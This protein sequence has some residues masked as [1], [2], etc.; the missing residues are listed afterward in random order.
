MIERDVRSSGG[1]H[2]I[3]A[4]LISEDESDDFSTSRD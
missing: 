2:A 3:L 1:P 4:F